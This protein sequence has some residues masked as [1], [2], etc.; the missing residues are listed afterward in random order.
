MG[1][2]KRIKESRQGAK[3]ILEQL[4]A[5]NAE[6]AQNE[7]QLAQLE[8]GKAEMLANMLLKENRT[9]QLGDILNPDQIQSVV[10]ILNRT[11]IDDIQQTKLIKSYLSQFSR[12]LQA[13]GVLPDYLAYVLIANAPMLRQMARNTSAGDDDPLAPPPNSQ[14]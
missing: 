5:L 7:A 4:N 10:N 12:E 2:K 14:N 3:S 1:K 9:M 6:I 8:A 11:D 13:I